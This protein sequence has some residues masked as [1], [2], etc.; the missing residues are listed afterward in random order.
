MC[1]V[2]QGVEENGIGKMAPGPEWPEGF[3]VYW[4]MTGF[5]RCRD[6]TDGKG[7]IP[8]LWIDGR[9]KTR[10]QIA[11]TNLCNMLMFLNVIDK[12]SANMYNINMSGGAPASMSVNIF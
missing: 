1:R 4:R 2:E 3:G 11:R 12:V 7:S 6:M 5:T 9:P 8:L 10:V